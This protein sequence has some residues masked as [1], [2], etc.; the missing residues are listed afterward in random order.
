[1]KCKQ[2]AVTLTVVILYLLNLCRDLKPEN[3]LIDFTGNIKMCDFGFAT[4]LGGKNSDV[5]NEGCGTA[6]YVAPEIT[7]GGKKG[8]GLAV[9]WWGLGCILFE[10]LTGR[11]SRGG[12]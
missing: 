3:I 12:M 5:S 1:M 11:Y 6:M 2:K 10:M 7:Q 4:V 8:H 9:D